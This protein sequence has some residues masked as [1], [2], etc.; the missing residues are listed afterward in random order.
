VSITGAI[1]SYVVRM[2]VTVLVGA[3]GAIVQSATI[4]LLYI[5]LRM[6]KEGL[7]LELTRF[8]E[9]RQSGATG[10]TDPYARNGAPAAPQPPSAASNESP[11]A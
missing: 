9:A 6:R 7:D 8:V 2:I 1:G 4:A 5:D 10:L 11:R 3:I